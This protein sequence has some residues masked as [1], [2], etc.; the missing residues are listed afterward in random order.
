MHNSPVIPPVRVALVNDHPLVT[1][2]LAGL[3]A[4]A[5][6]IEVVELDTLVPVISPVDVVLLDTYACAGPIGETIRDR[7]S[8]ETTSRLAVYTWQMDDDL[9]HD[10]LAAGASAVLSKALTAPELAHA[11]RTI[12]QGHRVVER[13]ASA[14]AADL[15]PDHGVKGRDW[16]G[17]REGLSMR[18]S[19]MISLICQ[20][21]SNEQIAQD[22]FLSPNS[23]KSYIRSAYRKIGATTRSQAVIWGLE[24][25]M[26]PSP[27]R[28]AG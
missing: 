17:R 12:R 25:Q 10:S 23:V 20:G 27:S 26:R 5:E 18:E 15:D 1:Q 11:L 3:L 19:E 8:D 2:G 6:G 14:V 4:D 21:L 22:L 24:H 28:Q 13:G 7:L 9:V 16:P